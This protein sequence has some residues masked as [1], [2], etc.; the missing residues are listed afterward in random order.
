MEQNLLRQV[1]GII[2]RC[3]NELLNTLYPAQVALGEPV[4]QASMEHVPGDAN[5]NHSSQTHGPSGPRMAGSTGGL[6][7]PSSTT[8]TIHRPQ[9][10]PGNI[11]QPSGQQMMQGQQYLPDTPGQGSGL[12]WDSSEWIDWNA[13]FPPVPEA[14]VPD[15]GEQFQSLNVTPVWT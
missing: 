10:A 9:L 12:P 14:Q 11:T 15:R 7:P 13:V 6:H 1:A 5:A 2:R 8:A 4:M 3:E